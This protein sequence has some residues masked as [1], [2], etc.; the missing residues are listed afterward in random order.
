MSSH[1]PML[2]AREARSLRR[3]DFHETPEIATRY[4][5]AA[6]DFSG[7]IWEPACGDGAISVVL[8]DA[9][10]EVISTDLV[11]RSYGVGRTDF[12]MEW[13]PRAP[14]IITNPP[15]KL[16]EQF[17]RQAVRLT[18]GKV[19][20]LCRLGWLEG[21]QRRRM[22]AELPFAR[23]WVFS[24]RLPMMHRSGF[25]GETN[26]SAIAFAWFVFEHGHTG[27]ATIGHLHEGMTL[28]KGRT[29]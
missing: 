22:F 25:V 7:P 28:N 9:G 14:N 6:E 3:D 24:G 4:L 21:R 26:S 23:L 12:L 1:L 15:F 29:I 10:H 18:T 13:L 5:L 19:A 8:E 11:Q 17:A 2:G 16:A 27:P 20:L